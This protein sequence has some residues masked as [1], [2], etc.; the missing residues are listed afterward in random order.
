VEWLGT[1][2]QKMYLVGKEKSCFL[3][4]ILLRDHLGEKATPVFSM[5]SS[6]LDGNVNVF[7]KR[8]A[9][10][11]PAPQPKGRGDPPALP[12]DLYK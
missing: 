5:G 4:F 2:K 9:I 12:G 10:G 3:S 8:H 11:H 7:C 6:K 1:V